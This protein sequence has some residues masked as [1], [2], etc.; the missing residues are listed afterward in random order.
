VLTFSLLRRFVLFLTCLWIGCFQHLLTNAALA[1]EFGGGGG[2]VTLGDDRLMPA[3]HAWVGGRSVLFESSFVG[4]K[5]SA[6]VQQI[7]FPRLSYFAALEK[8]KTSF[9]SVGLG[10]VIA[11]TKIYNI[12]SASESNEKLSSSAGIALGLHWIP[13]LTRDLRFRLSWNSMFIPP[14]TS[15]LYLTFGHMQSVT[16][17]LGWEF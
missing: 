16:A 6:F 17:G 1:F 3:T 14:G 4:E 10:G 7:A 15:V 8:S 2:F 11:R 13:K 9:A 12:N 5:N